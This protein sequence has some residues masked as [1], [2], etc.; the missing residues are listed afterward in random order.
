MSYTNNSS[1]LNPSIAS[2][3][4]ELIVIVKQEAGLRATPEGIASTAGV[5]I[6]PLANLLALENASLEL[7]FGE[8]EARLQQSVASLSPEAREGVP[9]LSIYYRVKADDEKLDGLASRLLEQNAVEAAYIKPPVE[10]AVMRAVPR[11]QEAVIS[12]ESINRMQPRADEA[13]AITPDFTS[14]QGYLNMAPEGIDARYAWTQL[15]GAGTGVNIID[16]EWGWN[17]SHED[18]RHAQGGVVGGTNSSRDNHGTAVIGELGGDRNRFGVTGICPD[19]HVSA[20]AFSMPSATAIRLAADR[21]NVGDLMLLEIHRPGPRFNFQGREDQRGYIAV[22][23]W[24]DDYAAIRYAVAK[25]IIVVEAA[26]NG[27][28]A[29]DDPLYDQRPSGFPTSWRNPFNPNNSSSDAV[30][31]GAGAPPQGTH[32]RDHG[33]DRS[34]LG[35]SNYGERVD[36][37]GWGREVTTTGYGDLQGGSSKNVH[38]TDQFSGT[39]SASPIVTGALACVQGILRAHNLTPLNSEQAR[40]LLRSTGSPQ[41]D[42]PNRPRT[43]RIGNRPNLR[44][45]I[46]QALSPAPLVVIYAHAN[47]QGASKALSEGR[48]FDVNSLGIGNDRLSSLRVPAGMQVTLYE[49]AHGLGR[50]KIFTQDTSYVGDDFND[51]T[52]SLKVENLND[53]R[54]PNFIAQVFQLTNAAR[55]RANLQPL[56]LNVLLSRAA[57]RH[58]ESIAYQDFFDHRG[59]DGSSPFDRIRNEGYQY[60]A[61]AENIAAGQ[62]TP[63]EVVQSWMAS[64]GHRTNILNPGYFDIGIGYEF[65]ANDTGRVRL[66]HYWT[67]TFGAPRS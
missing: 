36:A 11:Q 3:E 47:F 59:A 44:Q 26:G 64:S 29:L 45:L 54:I 65:L 52:S 31:V 21:L 49:H 51:I 56:R 48:Y 10:L 34:R 58:S 5:D 66:Q 55:A 62:S 24:P 13:P 46:Q 63:E 20:V 15:G 42:A 28:E 39:S 1:A 22:E 23:W 43:Q 8:N 67:Q 38:Y 9:D 7:L 2:G 50:S 17:F 6:T 18:L 4:R 37:Q 61:A 41:Q 27:A 30:L 40:R 16:L 33:P 32:S 60:S 53:G 12:S 57:Q 14:R 35:F 25:G 19:A